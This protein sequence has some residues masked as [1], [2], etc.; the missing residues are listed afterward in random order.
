MTTLDAVALWACWFDDLLAKAAGVFGR[1]EPRRNA[2][3]YV[4][5][6]LA[7]V[8]RKNTWQ[9]AEHAGHLTP[10][11]MQKL[12][13]QAK[14]SADRLRDQVCSWVVDQLGHPLGVLVVDETAF[15]KK[16]TKSA[17]VARQYTGVT[18][19][20][21]NCQVGVFLAYATAAGRALIDRALYL[22]KSWTEDQVRCQEA[23]IPQRSRRL[24]TKPELGR[25]M[26]ARA[27]RAKV[28][29]AWVAAD[30]VYGQD[31]RLR[32]WLEAQRIGYVPAVPC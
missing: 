26:I 1:V 14:W 9:L 11:R 32:A 28:P 2:R 13:N 18:G 5:A 19:Q 31:R 23:G 8:E 7:P 3:S 15:L 17:G 4:L 6:L 22:P 20:V 24:V 25:L 27:K 10:D 16:G 30:T 29:F 12:L 21:E